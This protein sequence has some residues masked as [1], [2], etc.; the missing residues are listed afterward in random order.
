MTNPNEPV[1]S[2]NKLSQGLTKKEYFAAQAMM[3]LIMSRQE[4]FTPEMLADKAVDMAEKLIERL[5]EHSR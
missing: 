4:V 3:G 1:L 5:N 2:Q